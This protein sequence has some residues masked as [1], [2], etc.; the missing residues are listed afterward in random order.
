MA[1]TDVVIITRMPIVHSLN[2]LIVRKNRRGK[3]ILWLKLK[4]D[5]YII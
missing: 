3:N 4:K 2:F 1:K 5:G